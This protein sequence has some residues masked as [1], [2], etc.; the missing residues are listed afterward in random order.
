[1]IEVH[2]IGSTSI[3]GIAAKPVLDLL[4]VVGS[5][6]ALDQARAALEALGYA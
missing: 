6:E 2:H 5:L 4:G 1:M 3:P